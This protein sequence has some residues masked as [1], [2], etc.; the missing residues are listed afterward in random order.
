MVIEVN[1]KGMA[2]PMPLIK[3]KRALSQYRTQDVIF[4]VLMSDKGAL[5]DLPAFC[6]QQLLDCRLLK[7]EPDIVFEIIRRNPL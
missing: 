2:C 6:K 5:L 1:A 3:L 4:R 7:T